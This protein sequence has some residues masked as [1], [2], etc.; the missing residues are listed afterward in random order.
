MP[1]PKFA[2]PEMGNGRNQDDMTNFI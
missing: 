1:Q 2:V